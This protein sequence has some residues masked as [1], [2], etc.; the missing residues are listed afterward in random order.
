MSDTDPPA[1]PVLAGRDALLTRIQQHLSAPTRAPVPLIL[2]PP[3]SGRSAILRELAARRDPNITLVLRPDLR[4]AFISET[5]WLQTLYGLAVEAAL[6]AGFSAGRLPEPPADPTADWRVWLRDVGLPELY[7]V[8]RPTRRFALLL[9]DVQHLLSAIQAGRLPADHPAYLYS[10]LSTQLGM[11]LTLPLSDEDALPSLAPLIEAEAVLRLRPLD[12][13][14]VGRLLAAMRGLPV[15]DA[16]TDLV[17]RAT[18]GHAAWA[19]AFADA[20]LN[21]GDWSEEGAAAARSQVYAAL[22]AELAA[23]WARCTP[24]EQ[25]VL[26]AVAALRYA[27]P[28]RTLH[29]AQVETWLAEGEFALDLTT[30][31]AAVRGLEYTDLLM[32]TPRGLTIR[33]GL[34]ASWVLQQTPQTA[35]A[36]PPVPQATQPRWALVGAGLV[37]VALFLLTLAVALTLSQPTPPFDAATALPTVT[38][39]VEG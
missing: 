13:A 25:R 33:A 12:Q 37:L 24:A 31:N 4:A 35:S 20:L 3:G 30:I 10:L 32:P 21:T 6:A 17:I 34:V 2:G 9:D 1:P 22:N 36:V 15:A 11:T 19:M 23:T 8:I 39:G 28:Q 7:A 29:A 16:I 27:D 5:A 14:A 26:M 18:G 38:L